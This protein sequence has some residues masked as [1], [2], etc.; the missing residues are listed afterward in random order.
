VGVAGALAASGAGRLAD[1]RGARLGVGL[2]FAALA[3]AFA[4]MFLARYSLTGLVA[5][6]VLLDLGVQ[7]VHI[8]NQVRV[9]ALPAELHSRLNTVYMVSY[10][11]GG[12]LGSLLG[13]WAWG[14]WGW[15]GVC[16][17]SI[18]M[19][20]V[21]LLAHAAGARRHTSAGGSL[22]GSSDR[23]PDARAG[24]GPTAPGG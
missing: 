18:G 24:S 21:G 10:F 15:S 8:S 2:G 7:G 11:L 1:R 22:A 17:V 19:L 14:R 16:A 3:A 6:V 4:A 20:A 12:A 13:S 9:Y 23:V 5:G